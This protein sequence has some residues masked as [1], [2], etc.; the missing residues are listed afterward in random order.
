MR[1][2]ILDRSESKVLYCST[3]ISLNKVIVS[4]SPVHGVFNHLS[5]RLLEQISFFFS[6]KVLI[7][8]HEADEPSFQKHSLLYYSIRIH[9]VNKATPRTFTSC[10]RE[11]FSTRVT[12]KIKFFSI[13]YDFEISQKPIMK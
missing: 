5:F 12:K 9:H 3:F 7:G 11:S 2:R 1:F 10:K 6:F 8:I 4:Q 13:C